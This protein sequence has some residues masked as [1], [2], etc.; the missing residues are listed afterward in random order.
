MVWDR[1][2]LSFI[3]VAAMDLL[4]APSSIFLAIC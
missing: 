1:D 4:L 2:E 3:N